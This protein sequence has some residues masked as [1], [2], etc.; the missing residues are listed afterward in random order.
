M[1]LILCLSSS[2]G[3]LCVDV[4]LVCDIHRG[5]F[6]FS[7]VWYFA[8]AT[9]QNP[10]CKEPCHGMSQMGVLREYVLNVESVLLIAEGLHPKRLSLQCGQLNM[11]P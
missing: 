4:S 11:D 5:C 2:V 3:L 7:F 8:P 6:P 1:C 10:Y 9:K